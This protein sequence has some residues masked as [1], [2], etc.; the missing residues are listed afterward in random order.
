MP[1]ARQRI[2]EPA[3]KS[4]DEV[5]DALR[6]VAEID[7][8]IEAMEAEAN[9]QIAAIK[10]ALQSQAQPLLDRKDV[11]GRLMK[12]FSETRKTTDFAG[13]KTLSFM[14]GQL[15]FRQSTKIVVRNVKAVIEALR[16]KAMADCIIVEEKVSKENLA[17]Y[18]DATLASVGVKRQSEDTFWY[19]PDRTK[20]QP[21]P[22]AA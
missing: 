7:M 2:E 4:W 8:Q 1:K 6:E 17:G 21:Q 5:N 15:G 9:R 16:G 19:E 3:L 12:E 22:P 20:V 14:F 18:D 11:L 13:R 10:D